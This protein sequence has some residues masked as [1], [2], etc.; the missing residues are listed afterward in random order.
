M[1]AGRETSLRTLPKDGPEKSMS[2]RTEQ[3]FERLC[4]IMLL[5]SDPRVWF[6]TVGELHRALSEELKK[7]DPLESG[8]RSEK[9][10]ATNMT[11]VFAPTIVISTD[12]G[13]FCTC[14]HRLSRRIV[15]SVGSP[16]TNWK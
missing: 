1:C 8:K 16:V 15:P 2:N 3:S 6:F 10:S 12:F 11:E 9:T 13:V 14:I 7:L 5:K 4:E